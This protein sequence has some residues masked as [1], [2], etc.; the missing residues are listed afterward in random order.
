MARAWPGRLAGWDGRMTNRAGWRA[1]TG[2]MAGDLTDGDGCGA[3]AV[4]GVQVQRAGAGRAVG[5]G[6]DGVGVGHVGC[7]QDEL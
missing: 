7:V 5:Q 6:G 1:R 3:G 4:R 2:R